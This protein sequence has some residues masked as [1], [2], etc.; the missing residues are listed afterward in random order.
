[1]EL[2]P[3]RDIWSKDLPC[4]ER[5]QMDGRIRPLDIK[6]AFNTLLLVKEVFEKHGLVFW[7][8]HGTLLGAIRDNSPIPWDDDIDCSMNFNQRHLV[9]PA[10]EELRKIGFYI[11]PSDRNKII[12]NEN[13]P[14]Y[15]LHLIFNGSKVEI[16]FFED[17]G[18]FWIYDEERCKKDLAHPAKFYTKLG[19]TNF[20]GTEFNTPNYVEEYLEMMYGPTWKIPDQNRKYTNNPAKL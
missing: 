5:G 19:K 18:D 4:W 15:D 10:L 20:M 14:Y 6:N 9:D 7:L 8:S 1:M 12:D 3:N 17:K 13:A 11:P 2:D 16:W